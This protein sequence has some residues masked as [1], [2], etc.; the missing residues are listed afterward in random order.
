MNEKLTKIFEFFSE[1]DITLPIDVKNSI[2]DVFNENNNIEE[3][4]IYFKE[5]VD[6]FESDITLTKSVNVHLEGNNDGQSVNVFS[7]YGGE[8]IE[9]SVS[10]FVKLY[11]K[12]Q[13]IEDITDIDLNKSRTRV[14][15]ETYAVVLIENVSWSVGVLSRHPKLYIYCPVIS[16]TEGV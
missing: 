14:N 3:V 10:E 16:N 12:G 2:E 4:N 11:D 6:L 15:P 13:I 8:N 7:Y 5:D 1:E 9:Y